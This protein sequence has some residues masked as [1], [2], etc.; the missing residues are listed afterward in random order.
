MYS[1]GGLIWPQW[2]RVHIFHYRLD[3]QVRGMLV[4]ASEMGVDRRIS[5]QRHRGEERGDEKPWKVR[6]GRGQHLECKQIN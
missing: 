2:K 4:G 5:S 6:L 3:A 1:R